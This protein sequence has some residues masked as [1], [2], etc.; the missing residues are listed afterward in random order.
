MVTLE[1]LCLSPDK[2]G[3]P[4][5]DLRLLMRSNVIVNCKS[6][7]T[8]YNNIFYIFRLKFSKEMKTL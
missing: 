7:N 3:L 4:E 8:Q 2:E 6:H 5:V 1:L